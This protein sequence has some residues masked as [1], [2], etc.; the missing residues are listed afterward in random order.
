MLSVI[1]LSVIMLSVIM[2]SVIMLSVIMLSVVAPMEQLIF[3]QSVSE[4][5]EI[6]TLTPKNSN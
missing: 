6:V 5:R 3:D 4:G 2:L 1:M